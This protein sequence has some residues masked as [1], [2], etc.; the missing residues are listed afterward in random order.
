MILVVAGMTPQSV[1]HFGDIPQTQ[2]LWA[3]FWLLVALVAKVASKGFI[4][5]AT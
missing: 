3:V 5:P 2:K 1:K 4:N